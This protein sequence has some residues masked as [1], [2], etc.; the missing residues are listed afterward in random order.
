MPSF[1]YISAALAPWV[2]ERFFSSLLLSPTPNEHFYWVECPASTTDFDE[3]FPSFLFLEA[4]SKK[5]SF[6]PV[7]IALVGPRLL[8]LFCQYTMKVLFVYGDIIGTENLQ[9]HVSSR[10]PN[11]QI[12]DLIANQEKWSNFVQLDALCSLMLIDFHL[13]RVENVAKIRLVC[14]L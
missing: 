4:P 1:S 6:S 10:P 12:R 8:P 13:E 9:K 3:M 5:P 11:I 7:F 2:I 14:N